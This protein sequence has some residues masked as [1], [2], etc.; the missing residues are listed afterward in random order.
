MYPGVCTICGRCFFKKIFQQ[1]FVLGL[2]ARTYTKKDLLV[3]ASCYLVHVG[4]KY[5]RR[6]Y[7]LT[8]INF[9]GLSRRW[10]KVLSDVEGH[11]KMLLPMK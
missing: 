5:D 2:E 8:I 11:V 1:Q 6:Q 4:T 10:N 9:S 7:L 3:A